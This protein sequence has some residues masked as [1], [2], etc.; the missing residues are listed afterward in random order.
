VP[1]L[2]TILGILGAAAF[3]Y[4]RMRDVGR[5]AGEAVDTVERLR[6]N[7]RRR[8]FR[9][10]AESSPVAAVEDPAAAAV[11]MLIKLASGPGR[12]SPEAETAIRDQMRDVMA[13]PQPDETFIFARWV[14][15]HANDPNDL[16]RR[17]SK[18]W[19]AQLQAGE[20]SDLYDMASRVAAL[21]GAPTDEQLGC[22]RLL[23]ERLGL[24]RP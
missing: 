23:H 8:R 18:L 21:G 14:A 12:L 15:D 20:R 19:M 10:R 9:Q 16:V 2:L 13:L 4:Y 3:W 1:V 22:L 11:A 24:T 7:F 6:G 5:A 17:F